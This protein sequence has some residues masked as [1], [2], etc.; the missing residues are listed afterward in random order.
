MGCR[1]LTEDGAVHKGQQGD[2]E[3]YLSPFFAERL[4]EDTDFAAVGLVEVGC[5]KRKVGGH[6]AGVVGE[7]PSSRDPV[8]K[9][10]QDLAEAVGL[11]AYFPLHNRTALGSDGRTLVGGFETLML[12]RE[13]RSHAEL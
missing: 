9:T 11:A 7:S 4:E 1:R 5:H 2:V 13:I 12:L 10:F 6:S 8:Y 3:S